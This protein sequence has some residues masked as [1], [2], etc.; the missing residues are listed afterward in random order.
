MNKKSR[1]WLSI[2]FPGICQVIDGNY[3]IGLPLLLINGAFFYFIW[4]ALMPISLA[5]T[6]QSIVVQEKEEAQSKEVWVKDLHE[7]LKG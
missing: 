7:I 2:L 6:L 5:L 3:R 1:I 4:I